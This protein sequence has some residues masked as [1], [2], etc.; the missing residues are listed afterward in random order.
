MD[1]ES[2]INRYVHESDEARVNNLYNSVKMYL[3]EIKD[4]KSRVA[5][6]HLLIRKLRDL[7]NEYQ[8]NM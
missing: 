1:L 3:N 2:L 5:A 4:M 8:K 6:I 7:S